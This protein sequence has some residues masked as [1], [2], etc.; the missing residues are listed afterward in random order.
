MVE[1]CL[2]AALL[3]ATLA[4]TFTYGYTFLQYNKL[5]SAVVQGARYASMIPYDSSSTTPSAAFLTSV[6][7]MALYGSPVAGDAPSVS[8]LTAGN[9]NLTVIFANGAPSTMTV[10]VNGYTVNSLFGSAPLV[11]KPK[12]T[13]SYHGIWS[14]Y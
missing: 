5:E 9:I 13:F 8:G 6:Q 10:S 7:N 4:G 12:A 1:F 2:G 3:L 11:N 14:P